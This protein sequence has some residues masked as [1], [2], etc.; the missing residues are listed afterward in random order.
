[1][2]RAGTGPFAFTS[3]ALA[4][5]LVATLACDVQSTEERTGG[6]PGLFGGAGGDQG[7]SG[8]PAA[9]HGGEGGAAP[10]RPNRPT[11]SRG[12]LVLNGDYLSVSVSIICS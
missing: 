5:T 1:M 6:V 9:G 3:V 4:M 8:G 2:R 12:L 11:A 10:G 7:R